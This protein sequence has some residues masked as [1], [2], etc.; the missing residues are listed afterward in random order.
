[1]GPVST[2][3]GA[4]K[5]GFLTSHIGTRR[6]F[7]ALESFHLHQARALPPVS[8]RG[9]VSRQKQI[10]KQAVHSKQNQISF[11]MSEESQHSFQHWPR[12][13]V[14]LFFSQFLPDNIF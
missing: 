14:L 3:P 10:G 13:E 4:S 11:A 9:I 1:M 6:I 7:L 8:I 12:S 5:L 2:L